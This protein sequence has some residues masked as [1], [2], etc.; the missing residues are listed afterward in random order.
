MTESKA[1]SRPSLTPAGCL[2]LLFSAS[3]SLCNDDHSV[4]RRKGRGEVREGGVGI[5]S[6][7]QR[8]GE[9]GINEYAEASKRCL[10]L[11]QAMTLSKID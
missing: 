3:C 8:G 11:V 5:G 9:V 7:K 1:F 10:V 6:S 2:M 4:A